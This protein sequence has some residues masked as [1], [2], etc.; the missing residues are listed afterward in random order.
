MNILVPVAAYH[1]YNTAIYVEK[2]L[3]QL[4]HQ[5]D[6]I[7][8]AEFYGNERPAAALKEQRELYITS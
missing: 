1:E 3:R 5:A 8:Q 7:T 6:V 4:G 2:A